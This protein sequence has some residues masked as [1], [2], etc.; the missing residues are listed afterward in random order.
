MVT[1]GNKHNQIEY[2]PQLHPSLEHGWLNITESLVVSEKEDIS[3]ADLHNQHCRPQAPPGKDNE[4]HGI[5]A[6]LLSHSVLQFHPVCS[7][8]YTYDHSP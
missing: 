7:F 6:R 2:Q 8:I 5:P 1:I 3:F 4:H